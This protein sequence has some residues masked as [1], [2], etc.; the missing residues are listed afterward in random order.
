MGGAAE[1]LGQDG[2]L[3]GGALGVFGINC[4]VDAGNDYGGVAGELAGSVNG[5][6]IPRAIGQ[7]GIREQGGFCLAEG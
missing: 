5:V 3:L 4:L 7:T 1:G 6:T 2:Q